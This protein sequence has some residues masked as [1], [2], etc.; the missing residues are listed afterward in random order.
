MKENLTKSYE[1]IASL[2]NDLKLKDEEIAKLKSNL[3][4]SKILGFKELKEESSSL[5]PSL[6]TNEISCPI[7]TFI[8]DVSSVKCGMCSAPFTKGGALEVWICLQ[9]TF[10]GIV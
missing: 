2:L 4:N 1:T 10:A 6:K 5:I 7:C 8:N 9:C 3:S